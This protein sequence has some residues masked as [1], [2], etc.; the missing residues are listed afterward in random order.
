MRGQ[1]VNPEQIPLQGLSNG[2]L[3]ARRSGTT[4]QAPRRLCA[5]MLNEETAKPW[6]IAL[7]EKTASPPKK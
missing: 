2:L 1:K 5:A 3:P 4:I 6:P 7:F